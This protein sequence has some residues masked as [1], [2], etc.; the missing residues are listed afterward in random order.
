MSRLNRL[1]TGAVHCRGRLA[2]S[3]VMVGLRKFLTSPT[4]MGVSAVAGIVAGAAAVLI[5]R[6]FSP[7]KRLLAWQTLA[8]SQGVSGDMGRRLA[9]R[10]LKHENLTGIDLRWS[11]LTDVD[12]TRGRLKY[13]KF[14]HSDLSNGRF[15]GAKLFGAYLDTSCCENADFRGAH[16]VEAWLRSARLVS[17]RLDGAHLERADLTGANLTNA[18]LTGATLGSAI[19]CGAGLGNAIGLTQEQV[20]SARGDDRTV[21]PMSLRRPESWPRG[22]S[23]GPGHR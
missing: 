6:D 12:L 23:C 11:V 9:L 16:L 13:A 20:E 4:L 14:Q 7:S 5:L 17:A 21:L 3:R 15:R 1:A 19:I 10:T 18:R 2:R 22:D 8:A